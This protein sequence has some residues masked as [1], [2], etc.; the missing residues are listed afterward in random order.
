M[1]N[2]ITF[3]KNWN[4][5]LD[6]KYFSTIRKFSKGK[7]FY[8]IERKGEVFDVILNGK[9]HCEAKLISV[10]TKLLVDIPDALIMTDTGLS[11]KEGVELLFRLG[12]E[13]YVIIL[14]FLRL[15]ENETIQPYKE[16]TI[17]GS[18]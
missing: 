3:I 15:D 14:T 7:Y 5:K 4:N 17:Q 10:E 6:Q 9:K 1:G 11:L 16:R 2:K 8:Y 13:Q 12:I 18:P